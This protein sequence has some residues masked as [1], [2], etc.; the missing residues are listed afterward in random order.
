[1]ESITDRKKRVRRVI[2]RLKK[3]YPDARCMLDFGSPLELL[4]ASILAAQCPDERV[5]AVTPGLF[6]TFPSAD[7]YAAATQQQ[8]VVSIR[9]IP[10]C[11]KK[12]KAIR[13]VCEVVVKEHNGRLPADVE[14]LSGLPGVG[15]KTANVVLGNAMGIPSLIVDTHVLRLSGRLGLASAHNVAKKYADKV[16]RELL[17]VVPAREH[18]VFSHLLAFH[19]RAVCTARKPL[20][21]QCPIERDCPWPDKTAAGL[22]DKPS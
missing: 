13:Q 20:C 7:D 16:E 22:L 15:R 17:E 10:F 3:A 4:V 5:N 1:M 18:T 11:M 21:L 12:A 19:G 8:V 9:T 6:K 14:A 2:S